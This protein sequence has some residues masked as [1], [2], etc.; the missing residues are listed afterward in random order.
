MT[1]LASPHAQLPRTP[2]GAGVLP[3]GRLYEPEDAGS[4]L[5]YRIAEA[6]A[7][8][9]VDAEKPAPFLL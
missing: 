5:Y 8:H 2:T 1:K 6:L 9:G 7:R 3:A 4:M